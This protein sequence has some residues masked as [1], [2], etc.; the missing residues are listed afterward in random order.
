MYRALIA[1]F[2][3]AA[4]ALSSNACYAQYDPT[5]VP[6][7]EELLRRSTPAEFFARNP[8]K[9]LTVTEDLRIDLDAD[10]VQDIVIAHENPANHPDGRATVTVSSGWTGEILARVHSAVAGDGFGTH[11]LAIPDLDGDGVRDLLVTAPN[12]GWARGRVDI[13]SGRTGAR[14]CSIQGTTDGGTFGHSVVAARVLGNQRAVIVGEPGAANNTGRV[15][16]FTYQTLVAADGGS[17][18]AGDADVVL[19]GPQQQSAFGYS[20]AA[21]ADLS[22]DGHDDLVVGAPAAH[23]PN[24]EGV[25]GRALI[26]NGVDLSM[27][28][29]VRS[30]APNTA[31]GASVLLLKPTAPDSPAR[32]L[33]GAP[34]ALIAAL[35]VNVTRGRVLGFTAEQFQT[36]GVTTLDDTAAFKTIQP[37]N[38]GLVHFGHRLEPA[39]DVN[40]DGVRDVIA[41]GVTLR[42]ARPEEIPPEMQGLTALQIGY[43]YYKIIL[44]AG[45]LSTLYAYPVETGSGRE[46]E[47]PFVPPVADGPDPNATISLKGVGDVDGSLAVDVHDL[48][49]V[50]SMFGQSGASIDDLDV[51]SDGVIDDLD[52]TVLLQNLGAAGAELL[53]RE[54]D[55]RMD[56]LPDPGSP[57]GIGTAPSLCDCLDELGGYFGIIIDDDECEG[58]PGGSGGGGGGGGGGPGGPQPCDNLPRTDEWECLSYAWCVAN[59][60]FGNQIQ[61]VD[62]ALA[63]LQDELEVHSQQVRDARAILDAWNANR[64]WDALTLITQIN[65]PFDRQVKKL[66]RQRNAKYLAAGTQIGIVAFFMPPVGAALAGGAVI[67]ESSFDVSGFNADLQVLEEQRQAAM[68]EINNAS[69]GLPA[70]PPNGVTGTAWYRLYGANGSAAGA[71]AAAMNLQNAI[72]NRNEFLDANRQRMLDLSNQRRNLQDQQQERRDQVM[73]ECMAELPVTP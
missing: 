58:G 42:P 43:D 24:G 72:R 59:N 63:A 25:S 33:I 14:I 31:L 39:N 22:G 41:H 32:L 50:M 4:G 3:V 38:A 44:N 73:D 28:R 17:L 19:N 27:Y 23:G 12:A 40:A 20:L 52:L 10:G 45:D 66:E 62:A 68:T 51:N 71:Q 65:I 13:F 8:T 1:C 64:E 61:Q 54:C 47:I 21:G 30:T 35:D 57:G 55:R 48:L 6:T 11:V 15:S 5:P 46:I 56:L 37:P 16:V 60:E 34:G 69:Q 36:A 2:A 18:T 70:I 7:L 29:M 67:V 53:S 49:A 26:Y 9:H